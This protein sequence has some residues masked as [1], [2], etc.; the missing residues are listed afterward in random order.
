[1]AEASELAAEMCLELVTGVVLDVGGNKVGGVDVSKLDVE[2]KGGDA[3]VCEV[4]R[5]GVVYGRL[6]SRCLCMLAEDVGLTLADDVWPMIGM[7]EC[8]VGMWW[9]A[10]RLAL[11][12]VGELM[13]V[14]VKEMQV[15]VMKVCEGR[16][17]AR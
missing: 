12:G 9:L 1:M 13:G 8:E 17:V 5:E 2:E 3:S 6:C 16:G 7:E 10:F 11:A 4:W 14:D 15:A